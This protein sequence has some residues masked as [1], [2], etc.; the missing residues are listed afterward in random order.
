MS[1]FLYYTACLFAIIVLE[2]FPRFLND[3]YRPFMLVERLVL[4]T[5]FLLVAWF[6]RYSLHSE[7]RW[8]ILSSMFFVDAIIAVGLALCLFL[9]LFSGWFVLLSG[10]L[11][12]LRAGVFSHLVA[13]RLKHL[14][15]FVFFTCFVLLLAGE[16]LLTLQ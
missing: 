3:V 4:I 5:L 1:R 12:L 8:S 9:Q 15:S 16:I 14:R 13:E 11:I 7:W 10:A 2:S 6:F